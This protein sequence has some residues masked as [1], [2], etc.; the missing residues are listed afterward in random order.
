L[1]H[2]PKKKV[3]R[4]ATGDLARRFH[5]LQRLRKQVRELETSM[6]IEQP[7]RDRRDQRRPT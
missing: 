6:G 5:E 1:E 7:A 4:L 2:Q 3:Q